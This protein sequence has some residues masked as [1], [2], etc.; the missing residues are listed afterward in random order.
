M[1]IEIEF[2]GTV[3]E[4]AGQYIEVLDQV[5]KWLKS[6]EIRSEIGWFEGKM[7]IKLEDLD[8]YCLW[9]STSRLDYTIVNRA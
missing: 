8:S 5:G 1:H 3:E 9:L 6:N 2:H 7:I 4:I